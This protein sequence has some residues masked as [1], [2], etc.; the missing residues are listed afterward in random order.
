[1]NINEVHWNFSDNGTKE[2][3]KPNFETSVTLN[4]LEFFDVVF[5]CYTQENEF[6]MYHYICVSL[7]NLGQRTS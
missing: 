7:S 4:R 2:T 3:A 1:M 6:Y 5:Y